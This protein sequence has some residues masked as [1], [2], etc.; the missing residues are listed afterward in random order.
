[1]AGIVNDKV[2]LVTGSGAGIGRGIA[3]LLAREGARVIVANRTPATGEETVARIVA[4]G[5]RAVFQRTDVRRQADCAAA[6]ER[7]VAEFGRLDCL[8]NNA[9]IFPRASL[10]ETT[11][12][13]WDNMLA[14]NLKGPYFLCQAAIPR[15]VAQGGGSV[16]NIGSINGLGGGAR[17]FAYSVSKGGLLTMTRNL[18]KAYARHQVRVNYVIPGWVITDTEIDI[19]ARDGHD[20][21]WIAEAARRLPGGRHQV[22]KDAAGTVLFL[23]SDYSEQVSGTVIHVDAGMSLI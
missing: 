4:A 2:A 10:E 3:E 6:I 20:A 21:A 12:T 16:V 17:L 9:A 23:C 5:G 15:M 1:M 19:Q 14:V 8:I 22:P 11:E 18:A 7:A 13:F